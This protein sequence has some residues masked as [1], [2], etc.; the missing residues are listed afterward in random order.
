MT[1]LLED[2][3]GNKASAEMVRNS[4]DANPE[5]R[6]TRKQLAAALQKGFDAWDTYQTARP[7]LFVLGLVMAGVGGTLAWKRRKQGK[8]APLA[9]GGM[10]AAGLGL[11][12]LTRPD[13]LLPAATPAAGSSPMMN[14][15]DGWVAQ[16]EKTPGWPDSTYRRLITTP[17]F[18]E[19]Y[20][21]LPAA[22]QAVLV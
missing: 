1:T 8:E 21:R 14:T 10:A 15:V 11:S 2:V 18:Q 13:W 16:Y 7:Y 4:L 22:V 3:L 9:W 17:G 20:A 19:Q 6:T 5:Y 12:W